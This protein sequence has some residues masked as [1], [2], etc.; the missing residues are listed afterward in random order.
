MWRFHKTTSSQLS[1]RFRLIDVF[2][3]AEADAR[4]QN[5]DDDPD[6]LWERIAPQGSIYRFNALSVEH[7]KHREDLQEQFA[8][9]AARCSSLLAAGAVSHHQDESGGSGLDQ[10]KYQQLLLK[11]LREAKVSDSARNLEQDDLIQGFSPLIEFLAPPAATRYCFG[12]VILPADSE[13]GRAHIKN[14][15]ITYLIMLAQLVGPVFIL[16]D[17][18]LDK[19]VQKHYVKPGS[20]RFASVYSTVEEALCFGSLEDSCVTFMGAI[21]LVLFIEITRTY[22][23]REAQNAEK[24]NFLPYDYFWLIVGQFANMWC[25]IWAVAAMPV[26]F[27]SEM[28]AKDIVYDSLGML[29]IFTLDDLACPALSYLML[30]DADFQR[31]GSWMVAALGQCPRN[32]NDLVNPEAKRSTEIWK[33]AIGQDG[34]I[35]ASGPDAGKRCKTRLMEVSSAD[36]GTPLAPS[37]LEASPGTSNCTPWASRYFEYSIW[38]KGGS[39]GVP[40]VVL[41]DCQKFSLRV[42]MWRCMAWLLLAVEIIVPIIFT[43]VNNPCSNAGQPEKRT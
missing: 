15:F 42:L 4:N 2:R 7:L 34:L 35:A 32:I 12:L 20:K 39:G 33:I 17:S 41:R 24:T 1:Q 16:T 23:L 30:D 26:L 21:F 3:V 25:M 11:S 9:L 40:S 31:I 43:I 6:A 18:W 13:S 5:E 8:D 14:R 22:A 37:P 19:K 38:H 28:D 10:P 36:E 27:L 29:F